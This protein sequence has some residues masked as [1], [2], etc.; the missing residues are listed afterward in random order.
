MAS[1]TL[2]YD[3]RNRMAQKALDCILSLGVFE[4]ALPTTGAD[5]TRQAIEGVERG[6]VIK[7]SSFDD[8]VKQMSDV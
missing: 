1:I 6:N 8:F 2:K 5:L 7:C 4:K 3:A